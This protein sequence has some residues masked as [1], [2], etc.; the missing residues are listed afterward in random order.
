VSNAFWYS[1]FGTQKKG[2][3]GH[4]QTYAQARRPTVSIQKNVFRFEISGEIMWE[5]REV[6]SQT[7]AHL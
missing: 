2:H 5:E 1:F 7:N 4:S 6:K 3:T